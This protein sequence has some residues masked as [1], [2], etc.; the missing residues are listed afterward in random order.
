M[1]WE[2]KHLSKL[3]AVKPVYGSALVNVR[4]ELVGINTAIAL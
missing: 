2:L 4:G 3:M 1:V